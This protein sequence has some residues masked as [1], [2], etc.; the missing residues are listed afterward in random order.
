MAIKTFLETVEGILAA[1]EGICK[2]TKAIWTYFRRPLPVSKP[3]IILAERVTTPTTDFRNGFLCGIG[4]LLLVVLA[5]SL[6]FHSAR[7]LRSGSFA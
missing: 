4:L 2:R 1:F 7:Q 6:A 3:G 5:A